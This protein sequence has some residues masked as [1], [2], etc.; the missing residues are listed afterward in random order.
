VSLTGIDANPNI[1]EIAR[2]A[3]TQLTG[4][5]FNTGNVL[6]ENF[7][8]HQFDVINCTLLLHHFN[9]EQL[10][11]FL[12][13]MRTVATTGI[14]IN[15]LHRHWFA[16]HSIRLLTHAFSGSGMVKNDAPLSVLR[17]FKRAELINI[18]NSSGATGYS[19][20]WRWAF[21]W[22]V[23]VRCNNY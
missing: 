13:K 19:I 21:R 1:I 15:D 14:V 7:K 8:D 3:S 18:L 6:S 9:D 12:K 4:I 2:N 11:Y 22:Q 16:Y 23:V 20:K 17:A 5:S 10:I